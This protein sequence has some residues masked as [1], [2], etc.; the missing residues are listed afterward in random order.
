MK[1]MYNLYIYFTSYSLFS[2]EKVLKS[3]SKVSV[4]H[5]YHVFS[6]QACTYVH[7]PVGG[8]R[9]LDCFGSLK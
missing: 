1:E 3:T 4:N 7:I 6:M 8:A 2:F 9:Y 5:L